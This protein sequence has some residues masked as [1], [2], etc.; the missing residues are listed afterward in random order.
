MVGTIGTGQAVGRIGYYTPFMIASACI[1]PIGI[2]LI[3]TFDLHTSEGKWIGF[4]ILLGLGLGMGMQQ[5]N[6]AAQ[7][8]LDK[9]D[10]PTGISLIFF[11][12]MLGGA[13]FI[14]VGQNVFDAGLI[15]GLTKIVKELNPMEVVNT[16]A[17][18]LRRIVPAKD[19]QGVLT[20]YNGALHK[21]FVLALVMSCLTILGAVFVEFRSV[22]GKQG[23]NGGEAGAE[24][25][26]TERKE[27][28]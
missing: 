19:L 25:E 10:V 1:V 16:G 8:V 20:A 22:K 21:V 28:V 2:G 23:S 18:D 3:T 14:S 4:Q 26:R 27:E 5:A 17:T 12:Q 7:T 15:S 6:I 11:C 13:I 24:Q 9:K